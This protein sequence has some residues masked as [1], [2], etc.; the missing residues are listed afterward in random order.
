MGTEHGGSRTV[1]SSATAFAIIEILDQLDQAGVSEVADEIDL[2]KSTVH[3]HLATL[4]ECEYVVK[5]DGTYRLSLKPLKYGRHAL[6]KIDV[7]QESQ[8]V[9]DH[10]AEETG[11]AVWTA[12]EEHGRA[13]YVNKALGDRA[14]PS[15]GGIGGRIALH[16]SAIGKALLAHLPEERVDEIIDRHGLTKL[17]ERTITDPN[18]LKEELEAVRD[19]GVSFNDGESL[20]GLRAIGSPILHHGEVKGAIAVAATA[21][22][23]K[24]EYFEEELPDM[25]TGTANEIEL[26]LTYS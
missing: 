26:K 5:E 21:N 23:M 18:V 9:I 12:V 7:A 6:E 13:V 24:G 11:E 19:R 8:P 22:R 10:L 4:E 3:K 14:V 25:V 15:R 17:T 20:E 1:K 16:S 2:A